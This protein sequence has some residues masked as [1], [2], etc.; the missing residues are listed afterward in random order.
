[1]H[2]M[3]TSR[4]LERHRLEMNFALTRWMGAAALAIF[5]VFAEGDRLPFSITALILVLGNYA[6]R[7]TSKRVT[8]LPQQK[9]LGVVAILFD[10]IVATSIIALASDSLVP[11]VYSLFIF[12][13]VEASIRFAPSKSIPFTFALV[14]T[15]Y[16]LILLK[17]MD[18]DLG[19]DLPMFIFWSLLTIF[20][21]ITVGT[22]VREIYRHNPITQQAALPSGLDK[23]LTRREQHI[24][25][26]IMG[27]HSNAYIAE[28]L[29]IEKKTVKNHINNI[30]SKLNLSSRYEA[31][32]LTVSQQQA[33]DL[34]EP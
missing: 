13:S 9:R 20:I 2:Q 33:V 12:I 4:I 14:T 27:G 29:F 11:A 34:D 24:L 22:G 32:V 25:T 8:T 1:M 23:I 17:S 3:T 7:L 10:S 16:L 21:G 28:A 19:F 15:L 31:I 6:L 5:A 26:L 30:Y 18:Q